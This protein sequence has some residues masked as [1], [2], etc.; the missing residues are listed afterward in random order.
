M[1]PHSIEGFESMGY[2]VFNGFVHFRVCQVEPFGLEDWIP[3]K[4]SGSPRY[5]DRSFGH[6]AEK[7]D[8]RSFGS[9]VISEGAKRFARMVLESR[10]HLMK[11]FGTNFRQKPLD[12]W[13][14]HSAQGVE[15]ET[16][17][18]YDDGRFH[19]LVS[20]QAFSAGDFVRFAWDW[21]EVI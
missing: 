6:P 11:S 21:V 18:F 16:R 17:V 15:A 10:Q 12:V 5:D 14:R 19:G 8:G 3:A 2:R 13:A 1:I 4:V 9:V 7:H 20:C